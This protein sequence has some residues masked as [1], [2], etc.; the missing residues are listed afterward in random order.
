M[1]PEVRL[2]FAAHTKLAPG[3]EMLEV[4]GADINGSLEDLVP[5]RVARTVVDI[6][7]GQGVDVVADFASYRHPITVNEIWCAEVLEHAPEWREILE[8]AYK[9]L[10]DFGAL[11][12]TCAGPARAPHGA[13][14]ESQPAPGEWYE[15]RSALEVEAA[16]FEAGFMT[17]DVWTVRDGQDLQLVAVR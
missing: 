3:D 13:W 16:L 8:S 9:N 1:H 4:G 2:F 10:C 12:A 15:N 11:L 14:G 7:P 6:R 5:R 17:V